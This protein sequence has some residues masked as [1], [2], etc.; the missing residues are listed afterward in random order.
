LSVFRTW[1]KQMS[2][3]RH[4]SNAV[5]LGLVPM[6]RELLTTIVQSP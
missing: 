5:S 2:L 3:G 6:A 1:R 4:L